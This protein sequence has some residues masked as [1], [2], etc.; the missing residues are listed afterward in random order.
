MKLLITIFLT[1]P[2]KITPVRTDPK[3]IT[4][5]AEHL[6]ATLLNHR[7]HEFRRNGKLMGIL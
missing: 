5:L 4:S 3:S 7:E 6:C 1:M 2:L